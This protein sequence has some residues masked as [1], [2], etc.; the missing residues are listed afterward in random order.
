[1]MAPIKKMT[2]FVGQKINKHQYYMGKTCYRCGNF[3]P[4]GAY[5][6]DNCGTPVNQTPT[7]PP[8]SPQEPQS[9]NR[10][11]LVALVT[12]LALVLAG[13]ITFYVINEKKKAKAEQELMMAQQAAEN[14]RLEQEKAAAEQRAREAEE[15]V[16]LAAERAETER[17]TGAF[18]FTGT[19]EKQSITM[20]LNVDHNGNATGWYYY[21]KYKK[22]LSLYGTYCAGY[23]T[24][25]EYNPDGM[26]CGTWSG[27]YNGRTVKGSMTNSYYQTFS[28][29]L[30]R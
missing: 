6:C 8:A 21:N 13:G 9:S 3:I 24:L 12:L 10:G 7:Y 27:S 11:L 2:K 1:M 22:K 19:V 25:E 14:A 16:R 26:W 23:M 20:H 15:A 5:F 18:N 28:F 17:E 29:R 4:D 30:N